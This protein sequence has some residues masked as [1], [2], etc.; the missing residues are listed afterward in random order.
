[1]MRG[2]VGVRRQ[3]V[4]PAD[5]TGEPGIER[6]QGTWHA[7]GDNAMAECNP[8]PFRAPTIR[9]CERGV[10]PTPPGVSD[11]HG[12]VDRC[13]LRSGRSATEGRRIGADRG[14]RAVFLDRDGTLIVDKPYS[15]DPDGI[16]LLGGVTEGLILLHEAGY[17][18]IVVTNQSAI[19]R[20]YYDEAALSRMHR[21]IDDLLCPS[22]VLISAY[23]F[24]PHHVEGIDP[25]LATPCHCRK[26][27]PGMILRA[28]RDW[29]IDLR[30][31]WLV[32]DSF[33]DCQ[34]AE[35]AGC[36]SVLLGERDPSA[37]YPAA[38]S[39]VVAAQRIIASDG[40]ALSRRLGG[41]R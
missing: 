33:T 36:R 6:A 20:G 2:S 32:G 11:G 37:R 16:E 4:C 1:M 35:R 15:S 18:L 5:A 3:R 28:A 8:V 23:Y 7:S 9:A 21:R 39:F 34:A 10:A 12:D 19:A 41:P 30:V 25:S 22:G 38:P 31:S 17:R 24:C 27:A 40:R 13:P 14:S 26:P 29:S